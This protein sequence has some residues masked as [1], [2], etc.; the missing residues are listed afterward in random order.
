M[1]QNKVINL[2]NLFLSLSEAVDLANSEISQHQQKTAY[3]CLEISK[4]AKFLPSLVRDLFIAALFH[5]VGAIS[6]EEKT[7]LK[8]FEEELNLVEHSERGAILLK[9]VPF[10]ERAAEIVRN[11][12]K[13]WQEWQLSWQEEVVR[14]SQILL[15]ADYVE[16]LVSHEQYILHQ[17]ESICEKITIISG[18]LVH[19]EIVGYFW[20]LA[21]KEEFWLDLTSPV[22]YSVLFHNGPLR[23]Y[24]IDF[25]ELETIS[26]FYRNLI[27]YKSP[28][29][30]THTAGVSS[31]AE[32]IS[33][34]FGLSE[35]EVLLMK[36]AG[37]F[38][39]LGKL[40]VP[41]RI[42]EK[43]GPLTKE[44]FDIIKSHTYYTYYIVNS[45]KGLEEIAAWAA[46]HHEKLT[47]DG[48]PFRCTKDELTIFARILAVSDI[49]TAL[50]EERPY[51]PGMEKEKVIKVFNDM[52]AKKELDETVVQLLFDNYDTIFEY[53]KSNQKL[54]EDFYNNIFIKL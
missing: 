29:T 16:R 15:L 14:A 12:H 34:L 42:L 2:G 48:Y 33:Q 39:D 28:F 21:K 11:H 17:K 53:V 24:Y 46:Y 13:P 35:G 54:A 32:I 26:L 8:N 3:I 5:D 45:I 23:N 47:G 38:H 41:N 43:P 49:F 9:T 10:F 44:E 1:R 25:S 18:D 27:D 36:I 50:T 22:L 51:R 19:E 20:H 4:L 40:V 7:S 30:A 6:V 52:L 31:C 37:N